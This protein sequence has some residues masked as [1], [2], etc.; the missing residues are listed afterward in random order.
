MEENHIRIVHGMLGINSYY[1]L[2]GSYDLNVGARA[3]QQDYN[4]RL[5]NA[6]ELVAEY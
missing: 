5:L 4:V 2:I 1:L 6:V 3:T